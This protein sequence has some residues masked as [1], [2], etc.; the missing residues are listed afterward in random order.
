MRTMLCNNG[1]VDNARLMSAAT[2]RFIPVRKW[3]CTAN[4]FDA[5][6]DVS[7]HKRRF[8]S[9]HPLNRRSCAS[10]RTHLKPSCT[11]APLKSFPHQLTIK[12]AQYE[13]IYNAPH[14]I[15]YEQPSVCESHHNSKGI[16]CLYPIT[17]MVRANNFV[18][19]RKKQVIKTHNL[20]MNFKNSGDGP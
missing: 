12:D 11:R 1:K 9:T 3:T 4:A 14:S 8:Q 7:Q 17:K 2:E 19:I 18:W 15:P 10:N 6:V 5:H 16:L 13:K 20:C